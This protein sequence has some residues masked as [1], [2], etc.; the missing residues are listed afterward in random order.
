[1]TLRCRTL[2]RSCV[3]RRAVKLR[4]SESDW[5]PTRPSLRDAHMSN[6]RHHVVVSKAVSFHRASNCQNLQVLR[7]LDCVS[8][9]TA[10]S[11]R[12]LLHLILLVYRNQQTC[13]QRSV[14]TG[15]TFQGSVYGGS[16]RGSQCPRLE[17]PKA[18]RFA[19]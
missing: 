8:G 5:M 11:P 19:A 17:K 14:L 9:F 15:L 7:N 18:G 13:R 10:L 1:M 2:R 12:P 16:L 6:D 4:S 3:L